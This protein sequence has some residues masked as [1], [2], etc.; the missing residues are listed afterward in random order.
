LA[1]ASTLHFTGKTSHNKDPMSF[2]TDSFLIGI[3]S[4]ATCCITD[5]KDDF[6]PGTVRKAHTRVEGIGGHQKGEWTGT[7]QWA[8][9]DDSGRQHEL[10]IPNTLLVQQGRLPFRLPSPQHF[11][12]ENYK[13]GVDSDIRGSGVRGQITNTKLQQ[14]V[15]KGVTSR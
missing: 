7:A 12:Q 2:D 14:P 3:D 6:V 5:N 10:R 13:S 15:P 9:T 4:C 1:N 8:V 11:A